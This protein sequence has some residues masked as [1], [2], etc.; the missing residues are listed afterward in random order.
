M[1]KNFNK[2]KKFGPRDSDRFGGRNSGGFRDR[3]EPS[4]MYHATCSECQADCEVPF[5][6]SPGK[7]V[8]CNN[9]FKR[10]NAR[11]DR[12]DRA[13]RGSDRRDFRHSGGRDFGGGRDRDFGGSRFEKKMY[14]AVCEECGDSCEVPFQPSGSKPVYCSNCFRKDDSPRAKKPDNSKKEFEQLNMKLDIILHRLDSLTGDQP[15]DKPASEKKEKKT[16]KE[17]KASP[18]NKPEKKT[19]SKNSSK[20]TSKTIKN[21]VVI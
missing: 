12:G 21:E 18:S 9:C 16:T 1:M 4:Q 2:G 5:R 17:K 19:S 13:D 15:A 10:D 11:S 8:Y 7:P 6:P 3:S 20:K 14:D